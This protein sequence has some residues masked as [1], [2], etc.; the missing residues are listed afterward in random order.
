MYLKIEETH[1]INVIKKDFNSPIV[2]RNNFN[3]IAIKKWNINYFKQCDIPVDVE[4]YKE[5]KDMNVNNVSKY[6]CV[7]INKALNEIMEDKSPYPYI[8]EFPITDDVSLNQDISCNMYDLRKPYSKIMFCGINSVS[9]FHLH[10]ED[11]FLLNQVCGKK[12]V[13]LMDAKLC[14]FK[15][16]PMYSSKSNFIKEDFL[17]MDHSGMHIYKVILNPGDSLLI[18]PWWYHLVV[19]HDFSVSVTNIYERDSY[20]YFW[21]Y[22]YLYVLYLIT[23][24]QERITPNVAIFIIVILMYIIY[25]MVC[26]ILKK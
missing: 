10:I 5:K 11:D 8:A 22:N 6:E 23:S 26:D 20:S 13:Y 14:N 21:D 2:L 19:G 3:P 17:S 16:N 15:I 18:P 25:C 24:I 12:T 7:P 9:G 4:Y 1:D